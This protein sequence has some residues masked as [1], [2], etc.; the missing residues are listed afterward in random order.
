VVQVEVVVQ[1]RLVICTG[2]SSR[3]QV[4]KGN[5]LDITGSA[6]QRGWWRWRGLHIPAF[7]SWAGGAGGGAGGNDVKP[8]QQWLLEQH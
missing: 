7:W 3:G 6:Y 4:V 1:E 2:R 8:C 5:I